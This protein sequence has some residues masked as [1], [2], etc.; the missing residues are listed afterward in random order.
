MFMASGFA[1]FAAVPFSEVAY[2]DDEEQVK[3]CIIV[4]DYMPSST[5]VTAKM[6]HELSVEFV[7]QGSNVTVVTPDPTLANA[8]EISQLDGVTVCRF[9]TG[10][11]KNSPKHVRLVNEML[12]SFKAWKTYKTY[13]KE[14]PHDLIV[15]WSPSIFWSGLVKRLK[16]LWRAPSYMLLRDFFPQWVIDSG[17][18]R[19][20]SLVVKFLRFFEKINYQ[21]ADMIALQSPKNIEWFSTVNRTDTPLDLLYNWASDNP[22][23]E[24]GNQYRK[25][26]GLEDK[27]VFFY[28][29]NVGHAQDMANIVRLA[30]SMLI[31]K[32]SHFVIVGKG[33]E[34]ELIQQAIEDAGLSNMTLLPPVPQNEYSLMLSE[35]DVGLFSLHRD[36][37]TH[38]FPG[39]LLAYMNQ[40]IPILG[41]VNVG[42]DL[43]GVIESAQA[44]FV[45]VNG[46]DDLLYENACKLMD[47]SLHQ[48]MGRNAKQLLRD[49]FSV[50]TAV[51]TIIRFYQKRQDGET[52][53][54]NE[55]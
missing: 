49:V 1:L 11:I 14:N 54:K 7:R 22:I 23:V 55:R 41:S 42:N 28:G 9:R 30:Q 36:H 34:F 32:K 19:E 12:L 40:G 31:E 10:K 38:N 52:K 5:K 29:G 18:L 26:Y 2:C 4:D 44:G 16:E 21:C 3:V 39:K 45:T 53:G 13:F 17:I 20:Q 27:V 8:Q 51:D 43:K 25:R 6:M 24:K 35:F 50:E 48:A 46:E 37:V 33:D 15:F 47:E